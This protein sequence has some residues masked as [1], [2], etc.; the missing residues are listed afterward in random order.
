MNNMQYARFEV[1]LFSMY[2]VEQCKLMQKIVI[3]YIII[4]N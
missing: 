1:F 4:R 3:Q 2:T